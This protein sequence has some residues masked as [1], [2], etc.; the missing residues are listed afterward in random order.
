M[1]RHP[2]SGLLLIGAL[3]AP[4]PGWAQIGRVPPP[5]QSGGATLQPTDSR[6]TGPAPAVTTDASKPT[7]I[8]L[9][10]DPV[11]NAVS[12]SVIRD[13]AGRPQTL[14]PSAYNLTTWT[15]G[16][17][18]PKTT[19]SYMVWVDFGPSGAY[20][21]TPSSTVTA[22]TAEARQPTNFTAELNGPGVV[23]LR[24]TAPP[25][26]TSY[27]VTRD[28]APVSNAKI[29]GTSFSQQLRDVGTFRYNVVAYYPLAGQN[30][31]EGDMTMVPTAT[32]APSTG[33]CLE[34]FGSGGGPRWTWGSY[35]S[36]IPGER[37]ALDTL[38]RKMATKSL[39]WVFAVASSSKAVALRMD[40]EDGASM[41]L[42]REDMIVRLAIKVAWEKEI[43]G[44]NV[45]QERAVTTVKQTKEGAPAVEMKIRRGFAQTDA[46]VFR[47]PK[48]LGVWTDMFHLDT[49]EPFW[50]FLG[51]KIVTF[52]WVQDN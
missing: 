30:D 20:A 51:G 15:D 29:T 50:N 40:V 37:L 8:A 3:L 33:L 44:W 4:T 25:G 1:C 35:D 11:P 24:W 23:V 26:A 28:G 12:Y 43:F 49:A 47:K 18:L 32:I 36:G 16:G 9:R 5:I 10:W 6:P 7:Q 27:W 38:M 48:V 46:I 52:T 13:P 34:A 42:S 21:R 31:I 17:L 14:T 39:P 19:A 45:C 22:T 2:I 41:N